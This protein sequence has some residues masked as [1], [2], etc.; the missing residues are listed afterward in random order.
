M[1]KL[2]SLENVVLTVVS[3]KIGDTFQEDWD[4]CDIGLVFRSAEESDPHVKYL[5]ANANLSVT[6]ELARN[7]KRGQ[8]F[9][10]VPI[11]D[12]EEAIV[13]Q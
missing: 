7:I 12:P 4:Y 3:I 13:R 1:K 9:R 8:K 6:E 5:L 10:L 2:E 11:T